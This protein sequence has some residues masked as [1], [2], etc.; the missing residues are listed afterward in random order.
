MPNV[1]EFERNKPVETHR[2]II[3][4]KEKYEKLVKDTV[5]MEDTDAVRVEMSRM[6]LNDLKN[7]FQK[8]VSGQ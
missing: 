8:F 6:F 1:S 5:V 2:A 4:T 7:I 3:S